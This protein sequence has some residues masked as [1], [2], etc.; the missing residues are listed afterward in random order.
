MKH[1]WMMVAVL[2]AHA[3]APMAQTVYESQDKSGVVFSD[4]PS[5]GASAVE[6]QAPNV[7]SAPDPTPRPAAQPKATAPPSYRRLVIA[8]PAEQATVHTNTGEFGISATAS[9]PLRSS[10]RVRALL[11]GNLLPS[12]Y[13]STNLRIS[14]SDWRAAAVGNDGEHTLQLAIVDADGKPWIES[15]PVRFYVRHAAVGGARR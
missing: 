14:E 8:R 15:A 1:R 11:D 4:R 10:D 3:M 9:P 7:V 2:S 13:R 6:L 5:A 12:L